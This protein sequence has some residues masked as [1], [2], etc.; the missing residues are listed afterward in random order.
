VRTTVWLKTAGSTDTRCVSRVES[1]MA[2]SG[3]EGLGSRSER[4]PPTSD[5]HACTIEIAVKN[6]AAW[7][8]VGAKFEGIGDAWLDAPSVV[9]VDGAEPAD[10]GA[11]VA[12]GPDA[13]AIAPPASP[14]R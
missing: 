13:P 2:W 1:G 6:D 10:G 4:V 12:P 14:A 7:I 3:G 11:A 9:P 8:F 5:W